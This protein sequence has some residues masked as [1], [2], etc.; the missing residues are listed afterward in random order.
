M[1]SLIPEINNFALDMEERESDISFLTEVWEKLE[2]R[3]HQFKL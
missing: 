2:N 1:R 3:K